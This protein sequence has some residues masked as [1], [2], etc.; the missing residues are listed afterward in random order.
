[1]FVA[2]TSCTFNNKSQCAKLPIATQRLLCGNLI[3]IDLPQIIQTNYFISI[4]S[5]RLYILK[6]NIKTVSD[7][8]T[9]RYLDMRPNI[10]SNNFLINS[11][12]P[13]CT[14]ESLI[15]LPVTCT[16]LNQFK[17]TLKNEHSL[18]FYTD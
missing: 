11:I 5:E 6:R 13:F 7:Q 14:I 1:M 16:L 10:V 3:D 4:N 8:V 12:S 18:T 2:C 15:A 9:L 17:L